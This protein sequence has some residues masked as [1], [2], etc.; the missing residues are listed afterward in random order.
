MSEAVLDIPVP[1]S[2]N[3]TRKVD[4][5]SLP[6]IKAWQ[7]QCDRQLMA[8][9]QFRKA[10]AANITRFELQIIVDERH[11]RCDLDNIAKSAI[12]YLKRTEIIPDDGP[13]YMRKFS[14]EFGE[15]RL[16]CRMILKPADHYDAN[17]DVTKSFEAAYEA[18]KQRVAKGGPGWAPK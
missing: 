9:L 4:R 1:P 2:V 12:D 14:V 16:G 8:S 5:A 15:A 13:A 7:V 6:M 11:C 3:R 10:K 18:V 17:D